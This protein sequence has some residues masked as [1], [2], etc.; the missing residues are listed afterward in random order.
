MIT[1]ALL[2]LVACIIALIGLVVTGLIALCWPLALILAVG[3][4]IDTLVLKKIF[5]H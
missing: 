4:I 1:L 5:G 3:I 2:L